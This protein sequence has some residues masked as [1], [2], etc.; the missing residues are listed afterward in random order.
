[1]SRQA[2]NL[3][4]FHQVISVCHTPLLWELAANIL[5]VEG[6]FA[7]MGNQQYANAV[8]VESIQRREQRRRERLGLSP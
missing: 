3:G 7:E 5:A 1:M 2:K 4:E 8:G 6:G